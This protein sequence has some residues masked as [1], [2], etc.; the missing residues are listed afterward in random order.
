MI[1]SFVDKIIPPLKFVGHSDKRA[2]NAI[3]TT[4]IVY[5]KIEPHFEK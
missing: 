5:G 1:K 3:T 2:T 4:E